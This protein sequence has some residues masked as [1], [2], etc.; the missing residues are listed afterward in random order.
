MTKREGPFQI[1]IVLPPVNYRLKLPKK[2]KMHDVFHVSLLTPYHE[3]Q[4]H[5]PNFSR[6]PPDIIDNEEEFKVECILHHHGEKK[7]SYQVKWTGYED[8]TWEPE[9]NLQRSSDLIADYWKRVKKPQK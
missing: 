5:G 7:I 9:E 3:N 4:V 6:P 8:T 2:W 1:L